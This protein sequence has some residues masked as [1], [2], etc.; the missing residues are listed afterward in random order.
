MVEYLG[1]QHGHRDKSMVIGSMAAIF[2]NCPAAIPTYF[3]Q[4]SQLVLARTD[5]DDNSLNRN[6]SFSIG[7]LAMRCPGMFQQ[8]LQPCLQALNGMFERSKEIDTKD[9]VVAAS[10]KIMLYHAAA[11]PFDQMYD[12]MNRNVPF[13]GDPEENETVLNVYMSLIEPHPEKVEPY[14][15]KIVLICLKILLDDK[16]EDIA[17]EFKQKVGVFIREKL[18]KHPTSVELLQQAEAKMNKD[19]KKTL[20]GYV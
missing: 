13:E 14:L 4:F 18:M 19:E 2:D 15:D 3:G 20:A 12:F 6:L 7:V 8:I 5:T 11:V 9:N 10:C 17:R 1:D 16:C